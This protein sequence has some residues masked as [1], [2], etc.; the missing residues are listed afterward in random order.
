MNYVLELARG[1]VRDV[2]PDGSGPA[3]GTFSCAEFGDCDP[4]GAT[5]AGT[6]RNIAPGFP[7]VRVLSHYFE[8]PIFRR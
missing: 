1:A 5:R 7:Q 2:L 4:S 3:D 6:C 8:Q